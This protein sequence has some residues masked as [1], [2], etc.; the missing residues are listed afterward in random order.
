MSRLGDAEAL[1]LLTL[2]GSSDVDLRG[3]EGEFAEEKIIES[4]IEPR[5][6]ADMGE[7][8]LSTTIPP[9]LTLFRPLPFPSIPC[10]SCEKEGRTGQRFKIGPPQPTENSRWSQTPS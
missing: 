2:R 5:S 10:S 7:T 9:T 6:R 1:L 4:V 8:H 3:H